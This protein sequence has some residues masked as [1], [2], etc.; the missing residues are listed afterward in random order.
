MNPRLLL[1]T[2]VLALGV[3]GTGARGAWASSSQPTTTSPSTTAPRL[4]AKAT[5]PDPVAVVSVGEGGDGVT[6]TV[7]VTDPS[8]DA[9]VRAA[10]PSVNAIGWRCPV[11]GAKFTNDYGAARSGG[12]SHAGTDMLAG[13]GTPIVAPV[14]GTV[15]FDSSSRGGLSFYLDTPGGLQIFGAH[16]ESFGAAGRVEPGTVIGY[17]GDSGN[18]K[19]TPH[20]HIEVHPTRKSKTNPF[21]LL[22]Q[23]C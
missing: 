22:K 13:R 19:G 11:S 18:A 17:V 16:L 21:P 7:G 1:A 9:Q 20:L 2:A 14:A 15:K 10:E 12:R 8:P 4:A 23:V 6:D 5:L 3:L